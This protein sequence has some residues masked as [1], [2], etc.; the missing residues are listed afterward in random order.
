M[1][2][3]SA[4]ALEFVKKGIQENKP[5]TQM[6]IQKLLYFAQGFYLAQYG[7]PLISESFQAWEYG[8]VI[9]EIYS[10]FK[11][12]GS[13]PIVDAS[14]LFFFTTDA[15]KIEIESQSF[16]DDAKSIIDFT[17][18]ALKDIDAIALSTWTHK[19][20]SPWKAHYKNGVIPNGELGAYFK[21]EFHK[22][23]Q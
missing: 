15:K 20:N 5:V 19:E 16:T 12:Y 23:S 2:P 17:W 8:P 3:A 14:T 7:S 13:S 22:E 11:I 21:K 4:I 9:P 1:Y 18:N 10:T 6:K